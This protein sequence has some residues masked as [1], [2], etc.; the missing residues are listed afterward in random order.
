MACPRAPGRRQTEP[1]WLQKAAVDPKR[2]RKIRVNAPYHKTSTS[3]GYTQGSQSPVQRAN[4]RVI[5]GS[6]FCEIPVFM[7]FSGPE[8]KFGKK[9][10]GPW[11]LFYLPLGSR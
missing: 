6:M 8:P 4:V 5:P 10:G 3:G 7:F 2:N 11:P 9:D 1:P